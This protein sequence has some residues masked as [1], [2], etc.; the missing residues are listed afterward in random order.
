MVLFLLSMSRV[1][2]RPPPPLLLLPPALLV[3]LVLVCRVHQG[4]FPSVP[5]L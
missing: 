1:P 4:L 2:A 3:L 5:R